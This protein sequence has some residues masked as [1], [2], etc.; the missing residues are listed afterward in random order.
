MD[1]DRIRELLEVAAQSDAAEVEFEE[2]GMKLV[3]RRNAPPVIVQPQV[4]LPSVGEMPQAAPAVAA[5][6]PMPAAT[7]AAPVEA[8]P[9]PEA[10]GDGVVVNAPTPGTYYEASTPDADPFVTVGD[11]VE[12]GDTLCIIEAMKL[13]NEIESE[14]AGTIREVYT[15]N[16]EP[17]EYDQPLF[18]IEPA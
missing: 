11:A 4:M 7:K 8:A 13:M 10:V 16:G 3:V 6:A 5:P 12:V 2:G 14:V 15:Q 9:K 18:L 1:I 17:V